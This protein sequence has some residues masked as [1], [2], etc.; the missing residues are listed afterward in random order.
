MP[1]LAKAVPE[2][3]ETVTIY[4]HADKSG[5][6]GAFKLAATLSRRGVEVFV[7]GIAW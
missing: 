6:K 2:Y 5:R 1:V 3:I 7:E 4:A